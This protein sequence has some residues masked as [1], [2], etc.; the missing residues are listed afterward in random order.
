[1]KL[2][3]VNEKVDIACERVKTRYGF[4]HD[5]RLIVNGGEVNKVKCCYYN[6]T[7]ERFEFDT[8]IHKLLDETDVLTKR[9]KINFW[10]K[11]NGVEKKKIDDSFKTIC[12]VAKLGE[13]FCENKKEKNDW[14]ARMLKAGLEN[15]GLIMPEDWDTLDEDTKEARLDLVI[16]ELSKG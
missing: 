5:A 13:F 4:R 6:R 8:V 12:N 2:F 10:D 7:W 15:K 16:G 11:R 1:M 14:K 3:K 9:Q